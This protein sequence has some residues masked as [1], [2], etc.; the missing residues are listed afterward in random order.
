MN[1]KYFALPLCLMILAYFGSGCSSQNDSSYGYKKSSV[2]SKPEYS[3][4]ESEQKQTHQLTGKV[5]NEARVIKL[6]AFQFGFDPEKIYVMEDEK[7]KI[8]AKSKDVTHGFGISELNINQ[9][10]PPNE[11][12]VIEFTP[13]E[14]GE[15]QFRCTVYCGSGHSRMKGKLIVKEK[16]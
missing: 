3:E 5:E 1:R 4:K 13:E 16:K 12:K 10:I 11:E 14:P 15:Y 9:E 2:A 6:S 8:I 7:V